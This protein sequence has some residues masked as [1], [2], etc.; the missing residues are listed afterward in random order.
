MTKQPLTEEDAI[1]LA[2]SK[3]WEPLSPEERVKFQL[4]EPL[5]CMPFAVFHEA[6]EHVL[7]RGVFSHEFAD[8]EALQKEYLGE[9][10]APT[11]EEIIAL[12]PMLREK[13]TKL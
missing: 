4:F 11:L 5:L 10:P 13:A 3:F 2:E 1:R 12:V 7:R 9:K 6:V 8:L